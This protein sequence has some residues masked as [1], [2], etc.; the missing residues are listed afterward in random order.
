[1]GAISDYLQLKVKLKEKIFLYVYYPK[2]SKQNK[3]NFSD[4]R[5][6]PFRHRRCILS[7][8]YFREFSKKFETTL[9]GYSGAPGNWFFRK[10]RS[11]KSRGTVPL[12]PWW[13]FWPCLLEQRPQ[14]RGQQRKRR[15]RTGD[16]GA[17][18]ATSKLFLFFRF[19]KS[20]IKN[21][22]LCNVFIS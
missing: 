21:R 8:E 4:W 13:V 17:L 2:V 9:I 20:L 5:F 18:T 14:R 6:F 19:I 16:T 15:T 7:C 22:L 12:S 11:R 3:K 10:P 1:M